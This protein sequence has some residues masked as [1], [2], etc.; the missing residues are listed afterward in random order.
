MKA[1]VLKSFGSPL[2]LQTIPD[3]VL[4]TGEVIVDVVATR[5]LS[6]ANEVLRCDRQFRQR[7]CGGGPGDGSGLRCRAGPKR[8]GAGAMGAHAP[9]H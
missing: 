4:G 5:V 7:W 2:E 9:S 3:P 8:E 6:Y 1:A